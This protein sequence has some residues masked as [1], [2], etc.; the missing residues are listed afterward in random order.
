MYF[1]DY[2]AQRAAQFI[3]E[4]QVLGNRFMLYTGYR[5]GIDDCVVIPRKVVKSI[6][7]NEFLKT[8]PLDPDVAVVDVKNK[9]MNMSRQQ[10]SQNDKNGFMI[11][12][13][14]GAKG[15]LFNVCQ[16]TGL[17]GQQYVNGE[18]LTDDMPQGTIFDQGFIVGSFGSGLTPKEFFSHVR[19]RITSLCDTA[20]TTSQTGSSQRKLIK[21]MEK[22]V[23]H[24]DGSVRWVSSKR[25]YEEEFAGDGIDPCRRVLD[26][27]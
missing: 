6:V 7:D 3:D 20:L 2:G 10:S 14:S 8:N 4:C 15:S 9:I 22:M 26:P 18:R 25:I 21:L 19:A 11:S 27:N 24:K 12:L 23:V 13:G 17:L 5:I 16:M 1:D